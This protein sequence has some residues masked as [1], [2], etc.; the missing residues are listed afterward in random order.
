MI[1]CLFTLDYEI[2]GNGEGDLKDLVYEPARK[3]KQIFDQ[4]GAKF[5]VFVEAAEL[6]KMEMGGT[7]PAINDV[8]NQI[9]ELH[10]QGYEVALHLH[11]QWC[12][13]CHRDGKWDLDYKEYNLCTLPENRITEI[14][15][16]SIT[17]L[18]TTLEVSDYTPI[19]FRAGNWLFQPTMTVAKVLAAHGIR[20]DSSVFKGGLQHQY[21]L[22][23]RRAAENGYFWRFQADVNSPDP[24]GI[25]VEIPIYTKMVPFWKMATAKRISLQQKAYSRRLVFRD[26]VYRLLDRARFRQPLKLDFCRMTLNELTAM[27]EDILKEDGQNPESFRPIVAIGHTKDLVD[28][29]TVE[30]FLFFLR[31][32][33]I[34]VSTF[35]DIYKNRLIVPD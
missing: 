6:E 20:I 10:Q 4:A 8:K 14:I 29:K 28:F 9:K 7:D 34:P 35:K 33:K 23:Y 5:V 31:E 32:K 26:K 19:S 3:L 21:G 13:A 2:Y 17:Y 30:D 1:E 25:L 16:R 11:P 12:N 22:D 18:R 27:M 24:N 15:D